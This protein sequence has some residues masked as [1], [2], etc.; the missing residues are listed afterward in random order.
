MLCVL[1]LLAL[2]GCT[3]IAPRDSPSEAVC[4]VCGGGFEPVAASHGVDASVAHSEAVVTVDAD[5]RAHWTVRADLHGP[6]VDRLADNESLVRRIV[7]DRDVWAAS[8]PARRPANLTGRVF[9]DT[10]VVTYTVG[11]FAARPFGD[12][13]VVDRYVR[14]PGL[15]PRRSHDKSGYRVRLL[16]PRNATAVRVPPGASAE[17][18]SMTWPSDA[19][20]SARRYPAFDLDGNVDPLV[21]EFAVAVEVATWAALPLAA[22]LAVAGGATLVLGAG[23]VART[24]G[25][26]GPVDR[27]RWR[28]RGRDHVSP[29]HRRGARREHTPASLGLIGVIGLAGAA[30][31]L[32][33]TDYAASRTVAFALVG[34]PTVPLATF[35]ALGMAVTRRPGAI[36]SLLTLLVGSTV[37][38]GLATVLEYGRAGAAVGVLV[39]TPVTLV[40]GA[41]AYLT[42]QRWDRA[43]RLLGG[44]GDR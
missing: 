43:S 21:V 24:V 34:V 1:A 15:R 32:V 23:L 3:G 22:F 37:V 30:A 29:A 41:G 8:V 42:V 5:G 17:A 4:G 10:L 7:R 40:I 9:G 27:V 44:S 6:D 35:A 39:W 31:V 26:P 20:M 19:A 14:P 2:A 11:E 33:A 25:R 16:A 38:L 28:L 36:R 12:V 13:L 18:N